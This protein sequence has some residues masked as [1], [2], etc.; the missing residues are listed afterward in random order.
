MFMYRFRTPIPRLGG[1]LCSFVPIHRESGPMFQK[2][3]RISLQGALTF[4]QST[5]GKRPQSDEAPL[6]AIRMTNKRMELP[7]KPQES[8]AKP[9]SITRKHTQ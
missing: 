1:N 2:G 7:T 9:I 6:T 5:I 8:P 3:Q 4:R